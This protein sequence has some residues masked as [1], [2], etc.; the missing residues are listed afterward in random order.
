MREEP[1]HQGSQNDSKA[2]QI[3]LIA[4][5]LKLSMVKNNYLEFIV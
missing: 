2:I 1:R 4:H 3:Q 5:S